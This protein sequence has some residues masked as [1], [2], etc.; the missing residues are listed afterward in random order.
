[1]IFVSSFAS[2]I[3]A[4][5]IVSVTGD[6]GGHARLGLK[7]D[8]GDRVAV[9]FEIDDHHLP[10][11]GVLADAGGV[12]TLQLPVIA[13]IHHMIHRDVVEFVAVH[14]FAF[15]IFSP[16]H[17]NLSALCPILCSLFRKSALRAGDGT[18]EKIIPSI[19]SAG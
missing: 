9:D 5:L 8:V 19:H 15:L 10:V 6:D 3:V 4:P 7:R 2:S 13:G 14:F 18:V 12:R 11:V 17:L 1:M 16:E